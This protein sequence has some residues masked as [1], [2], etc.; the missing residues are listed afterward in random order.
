MKIAVTGGRAYADHTTL[1]AAL[2]VFD[3]PAHPHQPKP[4]LLVG[5]ATG[6]D[7]MAVSFARTFKWDLEIFEADWETYGPSAG[8]RRNAEILTWH[9]DVLL[10]FPGGLGTANMVEQARRAGIPTFFVGKKGT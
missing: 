2:M 4:V 5:D 3:P 8:P 6:A 7:A 9:P 1:A 10:A